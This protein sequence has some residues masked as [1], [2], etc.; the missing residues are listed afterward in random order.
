[1][2]HSACDGDDI[3]QREVAYQR[4]AAEVI[5]IPG[6]QSSFNVLNLSAEY[7]RPQHSKIVL[8]LQL[9]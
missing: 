3:K 1:M 8:N 9:R 5:D 6:R 2:N 7:D 4:G